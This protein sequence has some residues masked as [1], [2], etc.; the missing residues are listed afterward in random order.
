MMLKQKY[1]NELRKKAKRRARK[2]MRMKERL[3]EQERMFQE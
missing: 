2:L 3:M 1:E